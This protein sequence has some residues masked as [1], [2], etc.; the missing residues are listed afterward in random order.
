MSRKSTIKHSHAIPNF[1][2]CIHL[3]LVV[4]G[5]ECHCEGI[6]VTN[7]PFGF[8]IKQL[9]FVLYHK[10]MLTC[11]C[12]TKCSQMEWQSRA[13]LDLG[14][15]NLNFLARKKQSHWASITETAKLKMPFSD[16]S[17]INFHQISWSH[18]NNNILLGP[19]AY[20]PKCVWRFW[21]LK[22]IIK[23][24]CH[25]HELSFVFRLSNILEVH[26]TIII[27]I[28]K[29]KT[30]IRKINK[31]EEKCCSRH[32]CVQSQTLFGKFQPVTPQL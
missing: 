29:R 4:C 26:K 8:V 13:K 30:D 2:Y 19:A 1:E 28:S 20:C 21:C 7:L 9:E 32:W 24:N 27:L 22:K 31:K 5:W 14:R 18:E 25:S 16:Q 6:I 23:L 10:G 11:A 15:R 17:P 3:A 12:H